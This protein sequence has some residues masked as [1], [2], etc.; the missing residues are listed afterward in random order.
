MF[1]ARAATHT[2]PERVLLPSC[3]TAPAPGRGL[4]LASSVRKEWR[5]RAS[6]DRQQWWGCVKPITFGRRLPPGESAA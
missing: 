5:M 1:P 2:G 6:S 4:W 3:R